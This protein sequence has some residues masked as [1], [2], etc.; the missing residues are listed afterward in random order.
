LDSVSLVLRVEFLC[1]SYHFCGAGVARS[2]IIFLAGAGAAL[3]CIDFRKKVVCFSISDPHSHWILIQLASW[4]RVRIG[5]AFD[6]LSRSGSA[7][8][9]YVPGSRRCKISQ[10]QQTKRK[11]GAKRQITHYKKCMKEYFKQ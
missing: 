1:N 9:K 2:R 10:N 3:K 8:G 7:F 5:S 6:W 11:N 4:V